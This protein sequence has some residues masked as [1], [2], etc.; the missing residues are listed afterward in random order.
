MKRNIKVGLAVAGITTALVVSGTTGAVA[1]KMITGA[2][3]KDGTI[4]RADLSDNINNKLDK[5]GEQGEQGEQGPAGPAGPKGDKGDKGEPGADSTV[6]GPTGATGA[7]GPQ[8]PQGPKGADGL[9]GAFYAVAYYNAGDT[10]P[11]AIATVAC[12]ATSQDYTALAG[13]VQIL[14]LDAG[15][16]ARN[17]PVSSSFPGRMDWDTNA[18]KANR[19]DGWIVQFGGHDSDP[20]PEKVKVWALCVPGT[21]VPVTPTFSQVG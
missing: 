11:G 4:S 16:N 13:G 7:Q 21:D 1:A 15:A 6:P 17:T 12:S 8:G 14:G 5:T 3:I 20:A 2:Q 18:P 10:N 19:L 9:T